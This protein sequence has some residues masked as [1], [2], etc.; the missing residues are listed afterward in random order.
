MGDPE[1]M[2]VGVAEE[3]H[4]RAGCRPMIEDKWSL[5]VVSALGAGPRRFTQLKRE[6]TGVSQRMLTV[7]L[8]SLERDG[9]ISRTVHNVMPAHVSYALTP[10]G[11]S[12]L[13]AVTPMLTWSHDNVKRIV[14]ARLEHD[15]RTP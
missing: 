3:T 2:M 10:L 12:F 11:A 6:I 5:T 13:E 9:I 7:T 15:A 14:E 4:R 1:R 8:R